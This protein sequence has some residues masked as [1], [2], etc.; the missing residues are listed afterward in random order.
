MNRMPRFVVP[1][2]LFGA[3]L[4]AFPFFFLRVALFA[5]IVGAAFRFIRR[6][7]MGGGPG[8]W[9]NWQNRRV[10]FADRIRRM[11]DDEYAA[12]TEPRQISRPDQPN[13]PDRNAE[14]FVL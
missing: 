6:R 12:F 4:V 10:E 7:A 13:S 8:G 1:A 11:S 2:I 5:L 3:A 9:G 14:N